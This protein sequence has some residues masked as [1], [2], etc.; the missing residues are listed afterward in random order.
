MNLLFAAPRIICPYANLAQLVGP[1][2]DHQACLLCCLLC[3]QVTEDRLYEWVRVVYLAVL[4]RGDTESWAALCVLRFPVLLQVEIAICPPSATL[5]WTEETMRQERSEVTVPLLNAVEVFLADR[6]H[7]GWDICGRAGLNNLT[8]GWS[9][10]KSSL[11][12]VHWL[13]TGLSVDWEN[14]RRCWHKPRKIDNFYQ[15]DVLLSD[16]GTM[17][18]LGAAARVH[19]WTS[20]TCQSLGR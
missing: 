8:L 6:A 16:W 15:F 4:L 2:F 14:L 19:H 17:V 12:V 1:P 10:Q 9:P 5:K 7:L 11:G 18:E 13:G 3:R 20:L